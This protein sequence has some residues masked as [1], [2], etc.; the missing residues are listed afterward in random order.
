MVLQYLGVV[1]QVL[2]L[3]VVSSSNHEHDGLKPTSTPLYNK[4]AGFPVSALLFT[5]KDKKAL[6]VK[7]PLCGSLVRGGVS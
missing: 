6:I 2:V 5:V 4:A 7:E 3:D 1:H